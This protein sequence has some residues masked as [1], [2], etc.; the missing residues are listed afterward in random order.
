MADKY[1]PIYASKLSED[2]F[3]EL[4]PELKALY[5]YLASCSE[6]LVSSISRW[7]F[8]RWRSTPRWTRR[9]GLITKFV[10]EDVINC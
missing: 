8:Q 2:E 1:N 3:V 10:L 7:G 9:S 6:S 4:P 5:F